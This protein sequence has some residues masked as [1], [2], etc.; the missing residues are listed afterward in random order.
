MSSPEEDPLSPGLYER[1]VDRLLEK[2]LG[3]LESASVK[4]DRVSVDSAEL[5][6]LLSRYLEKRLLSALRT[7]SGES[8]DNLRI[9]FA[10]RILALMAASS[11][12]SP[13]E[14]FSPAAMLV[15]VPPVSSG[16][17]SVLEPPLT[18]LSESTLLTGAPDD[19]SL[20]SELDKEIRS[21]DRIDILMSFIKWSGLRILRSALLDATDRGTVPVRVLTTTYL[22]ATEIACLDFL[23][24]LPGAEVR[25]SFDEHRT[26]LHAKAWLFER[27][28][29][30]STAYVGSSN[31]SNP[32]LTSGLEWNLKVTEEDQPGVLEKIRGTFETY[33]NEASTFVPYSS[34]RKADVQEILARSRNRD[35]SSDSLPFDIRPYPFQQEIL[36]R[37]EVEREVNGS[38]RNLVVSATGTGKT[39]IAAFDFRRFRE[40]RP[41]ATFLFVAHRKEILE[42]SL[43]HFR[44][45]LEDRNFGELWVAGS[46]PV[47]VRHVFAS[48]QSLD[49]AELDRISPERFDYVVIDEIHH[50]M[51]PTYRRLLE[52]LKPRILLGLTATPERSDGLD[53]RRYFNDRT[54]A[55]IRL[56]E[57]IDRN[58]LCPFHYFGI[59]DEV[60]Y[61][62]LRWER[63]QYDRRELEKVLTGNDLRN[64]S[65][66]RALREYCPD[67]SGVRGIGFCVGVRHAEEMSDLFNRAGIP[68]IALSADSSREVRDAV[69]ARISSGELTFVFV[70]DLYNEGIDIPAVDTVLF[71]RPTESLTI[72]L[73]QLGRGLRQ[74]WGKT[75]LTVLD[76]VGHMHEKFD[77]SSRLSA[78]SGQPAYRIQKEIEEGFPHLPAGCVIQLERVARAHVLENIRKALSFRRH[79]WLEK[80]RDMTADLNR[81]PH[82]REFFRAYHPPLSVL[83]RKEGKVFRGW[84]RFLV[85]A[86]VFPDFADPNEATLTRGIGRMLHLSAGRYPDLLMA[87]AGDDAV[88]EL[89]GRFPERQ[90]LMA[91]YAL[92]DE[93]PEKMGLER[94]SETVQRLRKNPV[95]CDELEE[96]LELAKD[97]ALFPVLGISRTEDVPLDVHGTYTRNE[98]LAAAGLFGFDRR[99]DVREGVRFVP[100]AKLDL[101]FVTLD[102]S[103]KEYSPSTMYEDYAL[104]DRLFHWQSQSTTGEHSPT[105]Q[106]YIHHRETGHRMFL[107]LRKKKKTA[108]HPFQ[109]SEPYVFAGPV[110]YRS[111]QGSRPMN[112]IWELAY[113]LPAHLFR[114]SARLGVRM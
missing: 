1:L 52:T 58:L 15:S 22:G 55:E 114:E 90:F 113:P 17:F 44:H 59:T 33:W 51:A 23:S 75:H 94:I 9:A 70:V 64:R 71:L 4:V 57:A 102:K 65:V 87:M 77:F 80:V 97:L 100:E 56:G 42:Q 62:N 18:G 101:L 92:W 66:L 103:E 107:F 47:H 36:D 39:V 84:K 2:R 111:H 83:Y 11:G 98:I 8:P 68:S 60:D 37:L 13:P 46:R 49:R 27:K 48:I 16:G 82:L 78:L 109:V 91:H 79:G 5:P 32:A 12:E 34:D 73:Q 21:A 108:N 89:E 76:F 106:R 10:N 30:F 28:S 95:L 3:D 93:T 29:G 54:A 38:F 96:M 63:G 35:D 67:L 25:I 110:F 69:S 72:F 24:S 14:L 43:K 99:V 105:G 112:V 81:P 45:I 6:F 31:I 41:D 50:G 20:A 104:S 85:E 53:V 61:R 40:K 88:E 86:G 7:L 19:P 74:R 26:R